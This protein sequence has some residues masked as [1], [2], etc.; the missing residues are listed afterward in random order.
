MITVNIDEH[1]FTPLPS[2][3]STKRS[4]FGGLLSAENSDQH[5][6]VIRDKP[7]SVIKADLIHAFLSVRFTFM[8]FEANAAK[9]KAK[10]N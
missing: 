4:W 3:E 10:T 6:I 7:L 1:G 2:P 5:T 9:S 8:S